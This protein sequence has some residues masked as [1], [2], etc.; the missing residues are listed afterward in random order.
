[1]QADHVRAACTLVQAIHVLG[2]QAQLARMA[3]C[4]VCQRTVRRIRL[5]LGHQIAPVLVPL[6]DT[7]RMGAKP[8]LGSHFLRVKLRPVTRML[9]TKRGH[10]RFRTH[11]SATEHHQAL[12]RLHPGTHTLQVLSVLVL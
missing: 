6:P 8:R 5:H 9:G 4:V 10:T 7:L 3:L 1:M 11:P 12:R 2:D